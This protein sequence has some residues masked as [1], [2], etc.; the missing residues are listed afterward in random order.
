MPLHYKHLFQEVRA[1]CDDNRACYHVRELVAEVAESGCLMR[2][3]SATALIALSV[4]PPSLSCP[5]I[6]LQRLS[7]A[8]ALPTLHLTA[9][10]A[11]T[12]C[13][14]VCPYAQQCPCL[15]HHS[16]VPRQQGSR[17]TGLVLLIQTTRHTRHTRHP[18]RHLPLA[19]ARS[20]VFPPVPS[21]QRVDEALQCLTK[22]ELRCRDPRDDGYVRNKR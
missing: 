22:P 9:P 3:R 7:M 5:R 6:P 15:G 10:Q 11:H 14:A 13:P 17:C 12:R 16:N 18:L 2:G 1:P 8:S 21:L 19:Q 20:G 4:I